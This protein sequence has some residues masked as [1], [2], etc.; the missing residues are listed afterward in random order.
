MMQQNSCSG[1]KRVTKIEKPKATV[2]IEVAFVLVYNFFKRVSL[3]DTGV[4]V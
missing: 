3:T 2:L 1:N 4:G